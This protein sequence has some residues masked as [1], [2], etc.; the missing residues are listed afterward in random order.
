M[1]NYNL[2][3]RSKW[4]TFYTL[5]HI[6]AQFEGGGI[7]NN[8]FTLNALKSKIIKLHFCSAKNLLKKFEICLI[9][10]PIIPEFFAQNFYLHPR[11]TLLLLGT[12][13]YA[14]FYAYIFKI[15]RI[16]KKANNL[17]KD[18]REI[19]RNYV[20]IYTTTR[21]YGKLRVAFFATHRY[22]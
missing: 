8:F 6:Q 7:K 5:I 19:T 17:R 3:F 22:V 1:L 18:L 9:W 10:V 21:N 16:E 4:V 20:K 14:C 15:L 13:N 12:R 2:P 11:I